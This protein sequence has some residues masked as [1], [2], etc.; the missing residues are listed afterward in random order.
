MLKLFELKIYISGGYSTYYH[1][2]LPPG[3]KWW[4]ASIIGNVEGPGI[5]LY[6]NTSSIDT[7]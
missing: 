1:A 4:A 2:N 7:A 6:G 5:L 3:A